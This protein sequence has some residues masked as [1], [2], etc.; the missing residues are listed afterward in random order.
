ML[1]LQ[2]HISAWNGPMLRI[3]HDSVHSAENF[4]A[5]GRAE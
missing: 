1:R 3:V 5:S 4:R 2:V